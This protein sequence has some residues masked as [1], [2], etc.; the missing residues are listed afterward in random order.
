MTAINIDIKASTSFLLREIY[1]LRSFQDAD[2]TTREIGLDRKVN[3]IVV[4]ENENM[5]V[6]AEPYDLVLTSGYIYRD[7]ADSLIKEMDA[8]KN[9]GATGLCMKKGRFKETEIQKVIKHANEINF[10][11]ILLPITSIFA[12][13]V[14]EGMEEI[15]YQQIL[16]FQEIQNTTEKLLNDMYLANTPEERLEVIENAFFNPVLIADS[17]NDFIMTKK[18]R[19]L[20]SEDVQNQIMHIK[21]N[22][23]SNSPVIIKDAEGD[24]IIPL[25]TFNTS[26]KDGVSMLLLEYIR[27]LADKDWI[28]LRQVGQ[29]IMLEMKNAMMVRKIERKYKQKFV[30]DL[31]SGKLEGEDP[32]KI[33]V[34]AQKEGYL[35]KTETMYSV[36]VID[37]LYN[38][39]ETKFTVNEVSIIRQ[40]LRHIDRNIIFT[41][42][43]GKLILILEVSNNHEVINNNLKM[44]Q[45]KLNYFLNDRKLSFYTSEP[46][47]IEKAHEAYLQARKIRDIAKNVNVQDNI[48]TMYT[49]GPAY[50]LST[51]NK[52][53]GRSYSESKLGKLI[54]YDKN[55]DSMLLDTLKCFLDCGGNKQTASKS[56]HVH[57]NTMVYRMSKIE[58]ILGYPPAEGNNPFELRLALY[59]HDFM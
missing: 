41:I 34:R 22:N 36:V 25:Y 37:T 32:L 15:L 23:R 2:I 4:I 58:E 43:E 21:Y 38:K 59:M 51:V 7:N 28:V 44:L 57:Y 9:V 11:F 1:L 49:L 24:R 14:Q 35:L 47:P 19:N 10:P 54:E 46:F 18:T 33:C 48:V 55:S 31:I 6:W 20:L 53:Y 50:L 26:I 56:L 27:P 16:D 29:S 30:D 5:S 17:E 42:E 39:E 13:V 52:E 8:L 40:S 45:E 12:S 3:R